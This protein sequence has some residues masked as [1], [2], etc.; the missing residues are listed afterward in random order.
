MMSPDPRKPLNKP[1]S[2]AIRLLLPLSLLG[3][4]KALRVSRG[5]VQKFPSSIL[6]FNLAK[7]GSM[8]DRFLSSSFSSRGRMW[9]VLH[10]AASTSEQV[11]NPLP[12]ALHEGLG[13]GSPIAKYLA[14]RAAGHGLQ[15]LAVIR[16]APYDLEGHDLAL[17][18]NGQM[19]LEAKEP[20]PWQ[21][22]S[23]PAGSSAWSKAAPPLMYPLSH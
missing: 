17:V 13:N 16:L 23:A 8:L 10:G 7:K 14:R 5:L 1:E 19:E 18:V 12:S 6:D 22:R 2:S 4:P 3:F 20:S 21:C 11:E 9:L 15:R